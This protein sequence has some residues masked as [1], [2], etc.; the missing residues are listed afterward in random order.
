MTVKPLQP[1]LRPALLIFAFCV[2]MIAASR[3]MGETYAVFLLPLSAEL[4]WNRAS[5]TSVY[6]VYMLAFG[7]GSLLSGLVYDR[8]GPCFNYLIGVILL[9]GCYG[10]AG[11]GLLTSLVAFYLAIGIC[12]GI[13]AAMVGIV[14]MQSLIS[15]WF[16]R[17]RATAVS[18]AYSGQGIGV[19]LLAP[20]AQIAI[21]RF[22]WQGAYLGASFGFIAV[23]ILVLLLP[24]RRIAAGRPVSAQ[25][26]RQTSAEAPA[27]PVALGPEGGLS[28]RQ[29]VR[30][31]EF[32]AFF[33]I[34]AA[35]AISIFAV[36]LQVVAF[37]VD[38]NF[39]VVQAAL[40]FGSIGMLTILG[41]ALTG[42]LSERF[43]RHLVATASYLLTLTGILAL[44]ALQWYPGW[45]LLVMFVLCF[46]LSAGARGPIITSQM[47]ELFAGRGLASIFGATNIGQGC[48]AALGA[49]MAGYLYDLTGGYNTGFGMSLA[50]ALVGLA[51]F[52][53]V[54]AIRQGRRR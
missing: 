10:L 26:P 14:P 42:I 53:L 49:F 4:D 41:I 3:G 17:G 31:I 6:S 24:W 39:S 54:P 15:K 29:A 43:P 7:F 5:V 22:G 37:L 46:G 9:V 30:R 32:W 1:T 21:D 51:T 48:G 36:S 35:S 19:M 33:T 20:T 47:A 12:G 28:L 23:L 44:A 50:F 8:L 11:S 27:T 18:I 25:Q 45:L 2:V 16:V 38:Q 52:W 40:A 34:Y 13:G